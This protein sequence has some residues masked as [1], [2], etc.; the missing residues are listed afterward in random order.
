MPAIT[1]PIADEA[2]PDNEQAKQLWIKETKALLWDGQIDAVL[3]A[4]EKWQ[5]L[6]AAQDAIS[7][8]T[9]QAHRMDYK[10]FREAG[11]FIG[12]GTIESACKQVASLRLKR[13]GARWSPRGAEAVAKARSAWLSGDNYWHRLFLAT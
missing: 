1:S 4:C 13:P 6:S 12:S 9:N 8:Y 7:Y 10:R 3:A 5:P 2:F 11:F